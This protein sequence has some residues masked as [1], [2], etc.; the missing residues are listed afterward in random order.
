MRSISVTAAE[1]LT[2]T[3]PMESDGVT[4]MIS[5]TTGSGYA[6]ILVVGAIGSISITAGLGVVL[7]AALTVGAGTTNSATTGL[8]DSVAPEAATLYAPITPAH[9]VAPLHVKVVLYEVAE[10]VN[11]RVAT[12]VP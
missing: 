7:K 12:T 11:T 8:T 5:V 10:A 1:G 3:G 9:C 2:I 6:V 4:G